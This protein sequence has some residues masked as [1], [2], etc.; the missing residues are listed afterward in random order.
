MYV[1]LALDLSGETKP[2]IKKI[3][4]KKNHKNQTVQL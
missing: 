4:I 2:F 3:K 1:L